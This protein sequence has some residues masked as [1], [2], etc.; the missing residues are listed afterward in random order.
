MLLLEVAPEEDVHNP[1]EPDGKTD[2]R[3]NP[4][5]DVQHL[6]LGRDREI[7]FPVV[8]GEAKIGKRERVKAA[9]D[10]IR[11]KRPGVLEIEAEKRAARRTDNLSR[12]GVNG[13]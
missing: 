12:A 11:R 8:S 10:V 1:R 2:D 4:I 7:L 6:R 9:I 13:A 5:H 3:E